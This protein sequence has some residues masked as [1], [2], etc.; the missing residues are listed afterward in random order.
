MPTQPPLVRETAF[1]FRSNEKLVHGSETESKQGCA[2]FGRNRQVRL[3]W[4]VEMQPRSSD[5]FSSSC[6]RYGCMSP[7]NNNTNTTNVRFGF[8]ECSCVGGLAGSYRIRSTRPSGTL[9][10]F[11]PSSSHHDM[12]C[13]RSPAFR[14]T[15]DSPQMAKDATLLFSVSY[16]L[17]H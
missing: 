13:P 5:L 12:Q 6:D 1:L 11:F 2:A 7:T 4:T 15:C 16:S 8:I 14:R 10:L 17:R 3:L 9:F